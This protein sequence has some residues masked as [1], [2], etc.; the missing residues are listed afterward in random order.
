MKRKSIKFRLTLWFTAILTVI[1]IVILLIVIIA[2]Q[3]LGTRDT[4]DLLTDSINKYAEK[5]LTHK[6]VSDAFQSD[7]ENMKVKSTDFLQHSVQIMA[8][9]KDG[10][11]SLGIFKFDEFD[12]IPYN[13]SETPTERILEGSK[14]YYY[15]SWINIPHE[16]DTGITA[17][18]P[19]K[20]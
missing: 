14:Y 9:H 18:Y 20:V 6:P 11:R 12:D 19:I 4:K 13:S 7:T 3:A 10:T 15:D 16:P 17:S 1:G 2:F 8:Y 5:I